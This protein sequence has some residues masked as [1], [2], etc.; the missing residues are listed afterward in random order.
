MYNK[1]FPNAKVTY[2]ES[3]TLPSLAFINSHVS[4]SSPKPY[5]SNMIEI[6]GININRNKSPLPKVTQIKLEPFLV[7]NVNPIFSGAR[8]IY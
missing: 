6:G 3:R 1:Y 8:R 7:E 5:A 4:T 2:D